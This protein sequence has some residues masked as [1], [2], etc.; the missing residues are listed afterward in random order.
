VNYRTRLFVIILAFLFIFKSLYLQ[1]RVKTISQIVEENEKAVVLIATAKETEGALSLGSGFI[2]NPNGVIITNYHVIQGAY[3]ALIKLINGDIYDNIAIVDT[4][5]RKD[6]AI[7]K[8]KRW[9]LPTV[10]LGNSDVINV[11]EKIVVIGNPQGLEN[12]VTDGLISAKRAKIIPIL[13]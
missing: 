3:P 7:I 12:T 6:I 4:D 13:Y 8:I 10:K 2:V 1:T 5:E 9:N 11:G